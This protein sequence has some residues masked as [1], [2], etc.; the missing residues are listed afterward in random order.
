MVFI[1]T[2]C[3]GVDVGLPSDL[4][5]PTCNLLSPCILIMKDEVS[6]S[7]QYKTRKYEVWT[8]SLATPLSWRSKD[9]EPHHG[10]GFLELHIHISTLVLLLPY[11]TTSCS[12]LSS[13][14]Q[15]TLIIDH[16]LRCL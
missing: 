2:V 9:P 6:T 1:R 8:S 14:V 16:V 10:I 4:Q 5:A 12:D 3:T 15:G 11:T 13:L 7:L